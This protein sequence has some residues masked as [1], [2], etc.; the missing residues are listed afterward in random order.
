M[1]LTFHLHAADQP[2]NPPVHAFILAGGRGSRLQGFTET[3]AKPAVAFAGTLRLLD[4]TLSNCLNSGVSQ[5]SLL[6]QYRSDSIERHLRG[7]WCSSAAPG[8][9]V[10][11]LPSARPGGYC[12]TANAVH[13]HLARLR[14]QLELSQVLHGHVLSGGVGVHPER[15]ACAARGAGDAGGAH[16]RIITLQVRHLEGHLP[17]PW[18]KRH[19]Q[20]RVA[21]VCHQPPFIVFVGEHPFGCGVRAHAAAVCA[22]RVAL[23]LYGQ[24]GIRPQRLHAAS[25]ERQ[26]MRSEL[27]RRHQVQ[28]QRG[29]DLGAQVSRVHVVERPDVVQAVVP[30]RVAQR[31]RRH[32]VER[33]Q[34]VDGI[35]DR[36]L[37]PA[38]VVRWHVHQHNRRAAREA[39]DLARQC[40]VAARA[41][42]PCV[43]VA[44]P[45]SS[46]RACRASRWR[47][48]F[49]S[50]HC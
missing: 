1:P 25:A 21:R 37:E 15:G 2:A 9:Q 40:L 11:V 32:L 28:R 44:S 8:V 26:Q 29:H 41:T 50:P 20:R 4:F 10:E 42:A 49:P 39:H 35:G 19:V 27:V 14:R 22:N 47:P 34:H 48:R 18:R 30:V 38:L 45:I 6:T 24:N 36:R 17:V 5:L 23:Q 43:S 7:N 3:R 33:E 12:G 31:H 46:R 16:L 13:Q